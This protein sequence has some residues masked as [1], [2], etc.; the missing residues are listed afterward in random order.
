MVKKNKR[1]ALGKGLSILLN[2]E[3]KSIN[4]DIDANISKRIWKS[5]IWSYVNFE[6]KYFKRK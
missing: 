3:N 2:D 1:K 4:N 5:M 6:R